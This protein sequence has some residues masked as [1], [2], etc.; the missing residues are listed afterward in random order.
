M[1]A[2][3]EKAC[4]DP[5]ACPPHCPALRRHGAVSPFA[6]R[7]CAAL[8]PTPEQTL[9]PF[10]PPELPLDH[11]NDLVQVTGAATQAIGQVTHVFGRVLDL[12]G[13]PIAGAKVEIWQCDANGRYLHPR[14]AGWGRCPAA[15]RVTARP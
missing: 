14:P 11:D 8:M 5:S 9:G 10:Y 7:P 13:Q 1:S 4:I 2:V 15:S 6:G 12:N 3:A